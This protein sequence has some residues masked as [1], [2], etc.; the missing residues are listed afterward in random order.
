[1]NV[2]AVLLF[3]VIDLF[4]LK[5]STIFHEVLNL[6]CHPKLTQALKLMISLFADL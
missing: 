6:T 3:F 1:M 2:S 5:V 4:I